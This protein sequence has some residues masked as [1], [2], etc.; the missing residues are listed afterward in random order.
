LVGTSV[1]REAP[2]RKGLRSNYRSLSLKL[3]IQ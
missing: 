2:L 1:S 3:S